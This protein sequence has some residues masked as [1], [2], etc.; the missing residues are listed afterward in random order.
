MDRLQAARQMRADGSQHTVDLT[1][2]ELGGETPP[3][4]RLEW[5]RPSRCPECNGRGYLDHID[6]VDRIMYEH[7]TECGHKW[8]ITQ[9]QTPA[10]VASSLEFVLEGLHLSKRLNK[11]AAGG[12]ATYRG[13]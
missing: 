12:K 2:A 10:A 4:P 6:M 11:E 9:A 5:G 1:A 7:C 13:R 3:K 8:T